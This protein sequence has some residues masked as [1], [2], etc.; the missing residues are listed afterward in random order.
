MR[1]FIPPYAFVVLLTMAPAA[2]AYIGPGAGISVIGS[3][4]GLLATILL[5][6]GAVLFW[7]FRRWWK[8]MRAAKVSANEED[9]ELSATLQQ[10]PAE[11]TAVD[12]GT[13]R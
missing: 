5:A 13:P 8:K 12:N 9:G 10:T 2:F 3:L 1:T 6:V 7:P 4:V 11:P